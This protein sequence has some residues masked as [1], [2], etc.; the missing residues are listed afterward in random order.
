[1]RCT[2]GRTGIPIEE[3]WKYWTSAAAFLDY[4]EKTVPRD[5]TL[6]LF[7]NNVFFDLQALAFFRDF[8][9]R[10]WRLDFVYDS[11][12]TYM[13]II[14]KD[15]LIIKAL[16][17]SNYWSA[18]TQ[19][20]GS[21][22]GEEKLTVDFA[23]VDDD[24]LSIYCFR[25]TEIAL[26]AMVRY[27]I[28]VQSADLGSFRLSRAA[29]AYAAWRHRFMET[30][31]FCHR[32]DEI[33]DL[34]EHAYMGGRAE[35]Y[36]IGPQA[37]GP[38][39]CYDINSMYPFIMSRYRLPVKCVDY[40]TDLTVSDALSLILEYSMI[41]EVELDT[42]DPLYAWRYR[43]KIIFPV[44][45]FTAFLCTEGLRQAL[46]R[47]HVVKIKRAAFYRDAVIFDKYVEEFY[48]LR[49]QAKA[50]GDPV[51]DRMA[52]LLMNSL[53][54]KLAQRRPIVV[55]EK[56]VKEG[57][58]SRFEAYDS[59]TRMNV[60][61]TRLFHKE[62]V[63][64]GDEIVPGAVVSIPAHITEYG[65]MLLYEIQEKF[66]RGEVLYC[67]TDSIFTRD[68]PERSIPYPV[69]SNTIGALS[70]KWTTGS[71]SI[72][73]AKDY[74]TDS[75][76]VLKG[77]PSSAELIGDRTWRFTFWPGQRTHLGCQIDDRYLQREVVKTADRPYDKGEV[78][79]DGR[80]I[81]WVLPD[82]LN[83]LAM[84]QSPS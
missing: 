82:C 2:I 13:L 40:H 23:T 62:T 66:G 47:G 19:E 46:M 44:G 71:L 64:M 54:G 16:S 61:T 65:R 38:F 35:A 78:L 50:N 8:T 72:Y 41:A 49:Q 7:A 53:Y 6:W 12:T 57:D 29:Q 30:R 28:L 59:V 34:E 32:D 33:R 70:K 81:P 42:G 11:Q 4:L 67:D 18:S 79:D 77:V 74:E 58:Y 37:G 68:R 75:E 69:E 52:K 43:S 17:V 20:L 24:T 48:A 15:R 83:S 25:D 1:M 10:G 56:A 5:S 45:R 76:M 14:R 21:L 3:T 80:V 26:D 55:S 63:T 60:I 84:N 39:A 31:V 51:T 36:R 27:F 73:G 9:D 22:L